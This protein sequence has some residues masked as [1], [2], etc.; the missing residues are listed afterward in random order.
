[1][2]QERVESQPPETLHIANYLALARQIMEIY[3]LQEASTHLRRHLAARKTL[4]T[5]WDW[6]PLTQ[7]KAEKISNSYFKKQESGQATLER[8]DQLA[9]KP[10]SASQIVKALNEM[11]SIITPR[12][13]RV[14]ELRFGTKDGQGRT[15][16]EVSQEFNRTRERIRQIE[17]KALRKLRHPSRSR[18]L[19]PFFE[20]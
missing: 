7:E 10:E 17:A 15:L 3:T 16:K 13:K 19:R 8:L 6:P 2:A 14:I 5:R 11:L 12:E 1:M 4:H 18:I 20:A 9:A